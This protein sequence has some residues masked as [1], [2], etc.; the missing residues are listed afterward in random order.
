MRL[1]DVEMRVIDTPVFQ[2]LRRIKQLAMADT[3]YP[4]CVHNRFLHS[5]GTMAMADAIWIHLE[6]RGDIKD[7]SPEQRQAVR[8]AALLHDV[9]HGPFSH[10]AE[11]LLER[12][13]DPARS[14]TSTS[15]IK[16]AWH[17]VI[18]CDIVREDPSLS[19]ALGDDLQARV[20]ELLQPSAERRFQRDIISSGLD[21][22]KL[23]YL[24]RDAYFAGVEYGRFDVAKV[25]DSCRI[26]PGS[27]SET[28]LAIH[29]EGRFAVEQMI[30][31]K[32]HMNQQV[33]AH[34]VRRVTDAMVVR[35]L[36]FAVLEGHSKVASLFEY[37]ADSGFLDR[38][39]RTHDDIIMTAML[40]DTQPSVPREIFQ[41]LYNRRLFKEAYSV[42]IQQAKVGDARV[43]TW[44]L[45]LFGNND[46]ARLR[47]SEVES[48]IAKV[49]GREPWEVIVLAESYPNPAYG[50]LAV[51][52]PEEIYVVSDYDEPRYLNELPDLV[53]FGSGVKAEDVR[54]AR[55]V[56]VIANEDGL[57][58]DTRGA[59][60]Q[61]IHEIL[62]ESAG[63]K[64]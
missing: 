4:G 29:E 13:S 5:I 52:N 8:L 20:C 28:F 25:V 12:F 49:I 45:G 7:P 19:T 21:A 16:R 40:E 36:E 33:Y 23:D 2:R 58:R 51:L 54:G 61:K 50:G 47:R 27:G 30:L 41:R 17:E 62:V 3:V 15:S 48:R 10:I 6:S 34:R 18:G 26:M 11:H 9:G 53:A 60:R 43:R 31:A 55:S 39:A 35:G 14:A 42:P 1:T 37:E 63:V 22:D 64:T 24:V 56:Y 44:L 57:D 38:Y 59:I 32:W 46:G